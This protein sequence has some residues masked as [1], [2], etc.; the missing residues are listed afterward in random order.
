MGEEVGNIVGVLVVG[1]IVGELVVGYGKVGFWVGENVGISA[2]VGEIVGTPVGDAPGVEGT[3]V[4]DI[5]EGN[6]G[7]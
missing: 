3:P 7:L 1:E 2:T 5:A 6:F 4:G